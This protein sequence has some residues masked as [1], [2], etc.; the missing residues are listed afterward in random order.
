MMR[1]NE[2]LTVGYEGLGIDEFVG[3]LKQ[4]N[5]SRLIDV[6]E[7]PL[8]RKPG[9][10]KTS[11][12]ERLKNENIEYVHIKA[13]GSPSP[14]RNKLKTDLDY[15]YFFKAYGMHLSKNIESIMEVYKLIHEGI[16]C[17]MC[18]E[19]FPDK[20]HRSAIAN[21]INEYDGNRLEIKHI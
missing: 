1:P 14:I 12:R 11:L 17:L 18:F 6:R 2:L 8:S 10:S 9:F 20:C 5:I 7:I 13:L 4:F 21:I 15:E 19:R 3:R 16:N